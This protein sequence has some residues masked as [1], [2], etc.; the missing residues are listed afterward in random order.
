M[1]SRIPCDADSSSSQKSK[2]S[3]VSKQSEETKISNET[4]ITAEQ[5]Q[6]AKALEISPEQYKKLV[7]IFEPKGNRNYDR[8][9]VSLLN[10][11]FYSKISIAIVVFRVKGSS[12]LTF[13]PE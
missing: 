11:R 13:A 5:I 8:V 10:I 2:E 1:S 6:R 9:A 7:N 4:E 12:L 3:A